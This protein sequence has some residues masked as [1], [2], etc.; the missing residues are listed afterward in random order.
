[1]NCFPPYQYITSWWV[2]GHQLTKSLMFSKPLLWISD[3]ADWLIIESS[4][5]LNMHVFGSVEGNQMS[6]PLLCL[7]ETPGVCVFPLCLS[8][9]PCGWLLGGGMA[10]VPTH[11]FLRTFNLQLIYSWSSLLLMAREFG[12]TSVHLCFCLTFFAL[13]C[14]GCLFFSL[15]G[16]FLP[17]FPAQSGAI[18]V[19]AYTQSTL[20]SSL[21]L[22]QVHLF[23]LRSLCFHT[24]VLYEPYV[25]PEKMETLLCIHCYHVAKIWEI[26]EIT[27]DEFK[28]LSFLC[29]TRLLHS[30]TRGGG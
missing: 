28:T 10:V 5:V 18:P 30:L 3:C 26:R 11:L 24:G 27:L 16:G 2:L 6:Q 9:S 25:T 21:K 8:L 13:V 29:T 1:M 22:S 12:C 14:L 17:V 23:C 19:P 4:N 20:S 7:L 15:I